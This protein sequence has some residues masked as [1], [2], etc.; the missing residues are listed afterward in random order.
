VLEFEGKEFKVEERTRFSLPPGG[1]G[2][3]FLLKQVTPERIVV[4]FMGADGKAVVR[5][6]GKK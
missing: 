3:E 2:G 5:E 4:E 1:E 6:I